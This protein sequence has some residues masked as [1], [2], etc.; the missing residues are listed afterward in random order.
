MQSKLLYLLGMLFCVFVAQISYAQNN[1]SIKGQVTSA[2]EKSGF[3]GVVIKLKGTS[4]ITRTDAN[5][6]YQIAAPQMVY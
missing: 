5:G 2:D 6:K 4:V 3:P 1:T